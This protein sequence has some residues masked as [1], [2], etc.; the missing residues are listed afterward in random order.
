MQKSYWT[1]T[2]QRPHRLLYL[3]LIR[4]GSIWRISY[5]AFMQLKC[6][7]S[8]HLLYNFKRFKQNLTL[9]LF[10]VGFMKRAPIKGGLRSPLWNK[11]LLRVCTK[12]THYQ[13]THICTIQSNS[14]VWIKLKDGQ[15]M[16]Q[17]GEHWATRILTDPPY[18][19][20]QCLQCIVLS[21]Y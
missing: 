16:P 6:F 8:T 21:V 12:I 7:I 17:I 19:L 1:F 13:I 2:R 3:L 10:W 18:S 14:W 9:T 15:L 5:G 20:K 4:L 11:N